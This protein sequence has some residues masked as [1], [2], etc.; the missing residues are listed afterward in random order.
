MKRP[1]N[2]PP[3]LLFAMLIAFVLQSCASAER[4]IETG[5]YDAAIE[6]AQ[7]RLV[8]K[9]KKNPDMVRLLEEAFIRA[10][11]R[12]MATAERLKADGQAANWTRIHDLYMRIDRRQNSIQPMLPLIDKNGYEAGFRFVQ[13]EDLERESRNNAAAYH[14]DRARTLLAQSREH[15]DKMA[16]RAAYRELESTRT[17]F[18]DYR[19]VNELLRTARQLGTVNVLVAVENS[20]GIIAPVEFERRLRQ[21]NTAELNSFWQQYHLNPQAAFTYDYRMTLRINGIAVSPEM[22]R[23]REY[24]DVKEIEDGFDYV[25]DDKGNV[26]KDSLGND[27]KT[28]RR[29]IVKAWVIE[30]QQFKQAD[31]QATLEVVDLRTQQI[32]RSQPIAASAQFDHYASTFRG[33]ERALSNDTRYRIGNRPAPFPSDELL[34]LQAADQLKPSLQARLVDYREII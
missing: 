11:E 18:R 15:D 22:V 34:I 33:D 29:V 30:V 7:R 25:L 24:T 17:Y 32:I 26:L 20:A 16:A 3:F 27:I 21:L 12:D 6:Y 31:V 2:A 1:V 8:G 23:E 5:D 14:Y 13:I 28:P 10:N 19:D 9:K 4:I